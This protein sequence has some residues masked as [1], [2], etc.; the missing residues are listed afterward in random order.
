MKTAADHNYYSFLEHDAY[1]EII[2]IERT[3]KGVRLKEN[4]SCADILK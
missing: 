2:T 3:E 4:F 1:Q